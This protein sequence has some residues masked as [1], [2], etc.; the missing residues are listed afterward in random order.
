MRKPRATDQVSTTQTV[1]S[2]MEGGSLPLRLA[3]KL[4]NSEPK[5]R[6]KKKY[7]FRKKRS[8][9]KMVRESRRKNR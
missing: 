9:D 2:E 7:D 4:F 6:S 3:R 5:K 1:E 8:K